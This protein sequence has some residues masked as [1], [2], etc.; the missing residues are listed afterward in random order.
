MKFKTTKKAIMANF[1][2]V[3]AV[4]YCGLQYLLNYDTPVAYTAS[5]EGWASDVYDIGEG[6]AI[7]TGYAPFGNVRPSR[8]VREIYEKQAMQILNNSNWEK[9]QYLL[10]E[11]QKAFI[12]EVK[13]NV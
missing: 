1:N 9:T 2:K 13:T 3:I 12:E 6:V 5:R 11:L 4:P 7:V 10:K 8:E